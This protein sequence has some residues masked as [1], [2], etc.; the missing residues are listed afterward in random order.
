MQS[1]PRG[2]QRTVKDKDRGT[3][4]VQILQHLLTP[5][6]CFFAAMFFG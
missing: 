2:V 6:I 5:V 3:L 1:W 4:K